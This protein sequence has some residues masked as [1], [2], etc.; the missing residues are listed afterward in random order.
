MGDRWR[1]SALLS[2]HQPV[3]QLMAWLA[4]TTFVFALGHTFS[5]EL[6]VIGFPKLLHPHGG[7]SPKTHSL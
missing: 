4:P 2:A 6:M 3:A 5:L 7:E 1:F